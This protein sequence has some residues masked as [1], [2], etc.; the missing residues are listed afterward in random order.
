MM[1][2]CNAHGVIPMWQAPAKEVEHEWFDNLTEVRIRDEGSMIRATTMAEVEFVGHRT[3][4]AG[5]DMGG[6]SSRVVA[7]NEEEKEEEE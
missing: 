3:I 5:L 6:S 7:P 4:E 1:P 2:E